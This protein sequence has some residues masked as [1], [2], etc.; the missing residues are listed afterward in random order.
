MTGSNIREEEM[1]LNI[2]T[3]LEILRFGRQTNITEDV[4]QTNLLKQHLVS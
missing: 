4:L 1:Q 3:F 2:L